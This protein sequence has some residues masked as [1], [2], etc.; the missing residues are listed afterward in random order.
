MAQIYHVIRERIREPHPPEF[1]IVVVDDDVP[2]EDRVGFVIGRTTDIEL[3]RK[4]AQ[5]YRDFQEGKFG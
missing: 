5:Y 2:D 1:L 4:N 3:A